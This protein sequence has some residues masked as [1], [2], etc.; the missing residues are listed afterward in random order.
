MVQC[1]VVSDIILSENVSVAV[2]YLVA[3]M[4]SEI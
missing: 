1:I 3:K 2:N 4:I